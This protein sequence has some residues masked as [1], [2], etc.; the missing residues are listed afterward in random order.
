MRQALLFL[1]RPLRIHPMCPKF[2]LICVITSKGR[3][4]EYGATSQAFAE[5]AE[6]LPVYQEQES[7]A[8]PAQEVVHV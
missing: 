6:I 8:I 1:G 4:L 7:E 3:V 5:L 2:G